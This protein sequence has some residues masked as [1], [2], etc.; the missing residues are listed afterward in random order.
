MRLSKV[1]KSV[2][3]SLAVLSAIIVCARWMRLAQSSKEGSNRAETVAVKLLGPD[4][5]PTVRQT[6]PRVVKTDAEWRQFL[7]PEQYKVTRRKGTERAFC[8]GLLTNRESG[9]YSC[10]CCGLPLFS[11]AAKFESGTGWP[12]FFLPFARENIAVPDDLQGLKW[13]EILCTRCGAHLGHVFDDGPPPTGLRYCLNS[14]AL[15]FTS[16]T[17]IKAGLATGVARLETATFAAGCF[18]HVEAVFRHLKGVLAT[19]VGYTG[20]TTANPSY[21]TVHSNK[22]GHAEAVEVT[23]DSSQIRYEDLLNVFWQNH[24]PTKKNGQGSP[25]VT[26]YR[27][28]IYYHTPEQEATALASKQRLE[29]SGT[30]AGPV[31][32]QIL[33][34]NTFWRAE[35]YHQRYLEKQGGPACQAM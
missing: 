2:L 5:N 34:T 21:E 24:D 31:L 12:S 33:P 9:I 26:A 25:G 23:Y 27:S 1:M 16:L 19:Q 4:G 35:E 14:A 20:G 18:W 13:S 8:G 30:H 32:T 29:E 15:C 11:S 3:I 22:T 17:D 10:V 7:N 6:V 28:A